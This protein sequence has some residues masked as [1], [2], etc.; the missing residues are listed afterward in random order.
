[1][2][3][4]FGGNGGVSVKLGTM[5]RVLLVLLLPVTLILPMPLSA[6]FVAIILSLVAVS[7]SIYSVGYGIVTILYAQS[8]SLGL[9]DAFAS[10]GGAIGNY[11]GGLIPT[12]YGFEAL[13]IFS[14]ILFAA[15]LVI[16]YFSR[17]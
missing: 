8:G 7:W 13:F 3:R 12:I 11:T 10:L 9:Y 4:V 14:G 16:F 17:V 5:M 6:I 2:D 1:V 15:A